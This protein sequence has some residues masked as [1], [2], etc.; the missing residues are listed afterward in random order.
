MKNN[1]FKI[2][3]GVIVGIFLALL[4]RCDPKCPEID[5]KIVTKTVTVEVPVD[6]IVYLS[7][8]ENA[9]TRT[10][11]VERVGSK[12]IVHKEDN[13]DY[14]IDMTEEF[15]QARQYHKG[16]KYKDSLVE[17][18]GVAVITADSLYEFKFDILSIK[19]N[20]K[21]ITNTVEAKRRL[22]LLFGS[23]IKFGTGVD[24]LRGVGFSLALKTRKDFIFE[25]GYDVNFAGLDNYRAGAKIP[26]F[27]RKK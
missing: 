15:R 13:Y 17:I 24:P 18:N 27:H 20:E 12:T 1:I 21:T 10:V 14:G 8:S 3:F 16:F 23:D 25:V 11:Y 6:R 7:D 19:Y 4:L 5:T 22:N 9:P 2:L 26:L